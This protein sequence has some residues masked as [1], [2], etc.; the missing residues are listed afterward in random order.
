MVSFNRK[1]TFSLALLFI[2][3]TSTLALRN[4]EKAKPSSCN[5]HVARIAM[6]AAC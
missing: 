1:I 4:F 2:V 3:A 6:Y 5:L